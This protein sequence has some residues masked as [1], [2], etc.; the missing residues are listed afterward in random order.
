MIGSVDV[1]RRGLIVA[2]LA[3]LV[4]ALVHGA[5]HA[6]AHVPLSRAANI[7][8]VIVILAGPF[9]GLALTGSAERLG[10]WVI[11]FTMAGSLV[12]G[13]VNHFVYDSADHVAHVALPWRGLFATTAVL[14]VLSESLGCILAIRCARERKGV[15]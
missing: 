4:V 15:A 1:A 12:F 7:F 13:L 2:V 9:V 6:E 8:V 10:N 14:L 11:A 3:H 5:T